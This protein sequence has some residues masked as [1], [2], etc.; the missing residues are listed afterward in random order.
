MQLDAWV[1]S[2]RWMTSAWP[3]AAC[4]RTVI[5][6]LRCRRWQSLPTPRLLQRSALTR[7]KL[8]WVVSPRIPGPTRSLAPRPTSWM[9]TPGFWPWPRRPGT[10]PLASPARRDTVPAATVSAAPGSGRVVATATV[11]AGGRRCLAWPVQRLSSSLHEGVRRK[12]P[13]TTRSALQNAIRPHPASMG[14]SVRHAGRWSSSAATDWSP[15]LTLI[16]RGRTA[17]IGLNGKRPGFAVGRRH[18]HLPGAM[19]RWTATGGGSDS[20]RAKHRVSPLWPE[21]AGGAEPVGLLRGRGSLLWVPN[22]LRPNWVCPAFCGLLRCDYVWM[23]LRC[24]LQSLAAQVQLRLSG[25]ILL[26]P[27]RILKQ[28]TFSVA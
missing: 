12:R 8:I 15:G 14:S 22:H 3:R 26:W 17:I 9:R 20:R 21:G 10:A 4:E 7:G 18:S 27:D 16:P 1:L 25:D 6:R 19:W 23:V 28:V 2:D 11:M 5:S 13:C 24:V